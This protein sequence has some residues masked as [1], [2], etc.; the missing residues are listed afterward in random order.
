MCKICEIA[1]TNSEYLT[2]L[3]NMVKEDQER[4]K[5]TSGFLDQFPSLSKNLYTSLKWPTK[6]STPLF[7]ARTAFAIPTKY[8]QP[9]LLDGERM[10]NHF[11]HGATRSVFFSGDRLVLLSKTLGQEAGRPFLSSFLFTHFEKD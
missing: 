6:F 3:E 5:A 4:L 8:F 10:G 11:A 9:L 1:S 7:E 2:L